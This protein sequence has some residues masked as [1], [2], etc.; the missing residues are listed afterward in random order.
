MYSHSVKANTIGDEAF[1]TA[2]TD[3]ALCFRCY[4]TLDCRNKHSHRSCGMSSAC[5]LLVN[6][7]YSTFS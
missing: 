4:R 2:L 5:F 7:N 6:F 1:Q 3:G